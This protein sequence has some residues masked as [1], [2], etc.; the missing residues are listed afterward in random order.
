MR[1]LA[2][3]LAA[4]FLAVSVHAAESGPPLGMLPQTVKPIAYRLQLTIDPAQK[5]FAGHVEI[6]ADLSEPTKQ[7]FL[8]GNQ[9]NVTKAE[10]KSARGAASA[11][12]TQVDDSGVARLDLPAELSPGRIT[13]SFDYTTGFRTGAEGLFRVEVGGNWYAWTQ[14]AAIDARRMFPGFDEPGFKTP[15]TITVTAPTGLKV[16]SNSPETGSSVSGAM[17]THRFAP[18]DPL[19]TYLVA[20]GVGPFDV[21]ETTVAA[22]A[23]RSKPI[24]MRVIATKGQTPR[25]QIAATEAPKMVALL[26]QYLRIPYPFAKLDLIGTPILGGAMENAGLIT[27]DDTLLLLDR[28]APT[29][30]VRRFGYVMAHEIAH[31]WFGDL[32]TPTWWT[33]IWLNESFATWLGHKIGEQ[34]RPELG[35]AV[36]ELQDALEAMADDSLGRG[37]PI[38]QTITENRQIASAFDTITYEKGAQVVAMFESY[39]GEDVFADGVRRHLNRYRFANAS[40]D[41]FFRSIS[42]SARDPKVVAALRT[43]TDQTGVPVLTLKESTKGIEVSQSRYRPLGVAEGAAQTWMIPMCLARGTA[44]SCSLLEKAS[45]TVP[46]LP[47]NGPLSGNAGGSGYYRYRLDAAAWDRL[48]ADAPKLPPRDALAMADSIWADFAAGTARFDQVVAAARA[49]STHSERLAAIELG[50]RLTGLAATTLDAGEL[51]R[52]HELMRSIYGPRLAAIGLD[53]R[54]DAYASAPIATRA[55]RESLVPLVALEGRD[56]AV[57]AQLTRAAEATL[58]GDSKALDPSFRMT[59]FRVATQDRGAPFMQKLQA[60]LV[61]SDDPLFRGQAASGIGAANTP[62]LANK[63]VEL[64]LAPGVQTMETMQIL[65]V[66]SE[67]RDA[68][69][70]LVSFVDRNFTR[71]M[72]AFP[73]F[74]RPMVIR[75][76]HGYCSQEDVARVEALV[77][78]KLKEL[79]G[80]EL[81]LAQAKER[82]RLCAA[83]KTAKGKEIATVLA[84]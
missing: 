36:S 49:L 23:I 29:G 72:E 80:G 42:E 21:V 34:W 25:M 79:G 30:Q 13:F 55:L 4:L 14:L 52:Y 12:Y 56:S 82:I 68:R 58:E 48:I 44:R 35:I 41:D 71:V 7:I 18:T 39:V 47:G 43:F 16:F 75:F 70:A 76:F 81:E 64:A 24:P 28:N 53:L 37:R 2:S 11:R 45:A 78:P 17:T 84:R 60:A 20:L 32:V 8:H 40:A 63:S 50:N 57:R 83:L 3:A 10:A 73:G 61:K 19:P 77:T 6:D 69:D 38:R 62:E 66:L 27:F 26:E 74:A 22:N 15:F 54:A 9:L 31:Q 51:P 59:A 46:S 5:D 65:F 67:Q 1:R 33:D